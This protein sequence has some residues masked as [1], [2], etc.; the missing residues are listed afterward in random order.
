MKEYKVV[1]KR[2]W[3]DVPKAEISTYKWVKNGYE[4]RAFTQLTY[5]DENIYV[6][7]TAY[8]T[9]VTVKATEYQGD[10]WKDSCMEFF[11]RPAG[12]E[13]YLN[14]ETN[15]YGVLLLHFGT[16]DERT[17]LNDIDPAIFAITP[18]IQNP[19]TFSGEKWT[20][21]YKIPFSFLRSLY[22]DFD[23]KDGLY[24]N[25]YKCGDETKYEHYG[26]WNEIEHCPPQFHLPEFF[27][28]ITFEM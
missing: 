16:Q 10:V 24:G 6:K 1:T 2:F 13:R 12:D 21:E 8:E 27:G 9:E 18:S 14:F 5:D 7:H 15:A 26:M 17:P 4:P 19:E 28:K 20:L 25:F 11:M 22:G 3:D 23:L